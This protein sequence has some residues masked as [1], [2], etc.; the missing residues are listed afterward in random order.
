MIKLRVCNPL[1][2]PSSSLK[3]KYIIG[4]DNLIPCTRCGICCTLSLCSKGR[5]KDKNKKGN[6]KFLIRHE[7]MTTSCQ[8]V[9]EGKMPTKS[10]DF[11]RGCAIQVNNPVAYQVQLNYLNYLK[12]KETSLQ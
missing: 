6:C 9:V 12:Q 7:D 5:R 1:S 2:P 11:E 4:V 8:L 3:P 10:I